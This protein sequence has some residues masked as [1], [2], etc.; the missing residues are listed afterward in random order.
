MATRCCPHDDWIAQPSRQR[1]LYH[2][3][4]CNVVICHDIDAD[5]W[6]ISHNPDDGQTIDAWERRRALEALDRWMTEREKVYGHD[7]FI[8]PDL[9]CP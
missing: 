1:Y 6:H 7:I 3:R 5:T 2:C 9:D 8:H 4:A